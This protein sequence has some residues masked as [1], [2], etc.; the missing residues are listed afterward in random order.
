MIKGKE[1]SGAQGEEGV[2]VVKNCVTAVDCNLGSIRN[3][4]C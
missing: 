1:R 3:G 2:A 4:N